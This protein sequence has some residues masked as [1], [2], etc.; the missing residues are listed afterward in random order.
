M[1]LAYA[2]WLPLSCLIAAI[3]GDIEM[4]AHLTEASSTK[5]SP[6]KDIPTEKVDREYQNISNKDEKQQISRSCHMH[7]LRGH[8]TI[9]GVILH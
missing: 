7:L 3:F 5:A 1:T 4:E 9:K 2:E 8:S 6:T